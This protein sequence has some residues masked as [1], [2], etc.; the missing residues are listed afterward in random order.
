M[1]ESKTKYF[2][3]RHKKCG[4]V[5]TINPEMFLKNFDNRNTGK[6]NTR[7]VIEPCPCCGDN[8]LKMDALESLL[9]AYQSSKKT[10]AGEENKGYSIEGIRELADSDPLK[11]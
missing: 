8:S 1:E 3:F 2:I 9:Q 7:I 4:G 6:A 10:L 5:F 11:I